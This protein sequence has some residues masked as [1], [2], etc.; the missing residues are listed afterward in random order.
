[1]LATAVIVFREVLEAALVI[2][3]VLSASRGVAGRGRWVLGGI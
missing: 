2:A 3:I 1:M